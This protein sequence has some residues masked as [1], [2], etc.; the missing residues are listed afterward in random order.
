MALFNVF[1]TLTFSFTHF[2]FVINDNDF[3]DSRSLL[4]NFSIKRFS[5]FKNYHDLNDAKK[6]MQNLHEL[7]KL[8]ER[9]DT[10]A[11]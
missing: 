7:T 8:H 1:I 3:E 2:A 6:L 10:H 9:D 5:K 11:K 4:E